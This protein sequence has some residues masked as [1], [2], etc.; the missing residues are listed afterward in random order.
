RDAR[1]RGA[2]WPRP[3]GRTHRRP[4]PARPRHRCLRRAAVR[5][6]RQG[7]HRPARPVVVRRGD[8]AM[9]APRWFTLGRVG[10]VGALIVVWTLLW[11][12]VSLPN[13]VS[14]F[15]VAVGLLVVFPLD[16]VE[17]VDHRIHPLGVIRLAAY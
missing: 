14:G 1:S 7:G 9:T 11:G 2:W 6:Q 12:E 8:A 3:H 4:A 16:E 15:V 13:V 17:H 10:L 5:P